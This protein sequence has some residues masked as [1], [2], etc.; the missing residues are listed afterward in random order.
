VVSHEGDGDGAG[1]NQPN[2]GAP[3]PPE[4]DPRGRRRAKRDQA[5]RATTGQA[6]GRVARDQPV[7]S[8]S[9]L[10]A[11]HDVKRGVGIGVR[12]VTA[13]LAVAIVVV[14]GWAWL[15]YHDFKSKI[16]RVNAIGGSGKP[17]TDLDGKDQ[18][19]LVVGN[20][21]R[22]TA[23]DAELR[24]LGTTRDG[25]SYNTDTM[26]V[27]HLPANGE[28]ATVI[29]FPRDSYVAIPGHGTAKLNSAYVDGMV[30]HN[31]NK[32]YG[33]RLLVQT[34]QNLTGL[35][36]DHFVQVDLLGFYRISNAIGG[37]QVNL[38]QAQH[39]ANSGIDL[40]KGVSTVK[41]TQALAFVR[42]RYGLP[43]GDLDR[44][45][46]QQY[47]LSAAFR[48][49]SSA[50]VLLNVFKLQKLLKAVSSSLQMDNSLDPLKLAEQFQALT[51][52]NLIFKTIPT[53]GTQDTDAGNVVVVE[54][55]EVKQ[56]VTQVV[57]SSA[58]SGFGSAKTVSPGSF[59]LDV[60]NGSTADGAASRNADALRQL[61]FRLGVVDTA[62]GRSATTVI[63][64]PDGMQAQAKTL[65][66]HIPGAQGKQTDS[67][68]RVTLLLGTDGL[69]VSAANSTHSFVQRA[70]TTPTPTSSNGMTAADT[71]A[72]IN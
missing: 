17:T 54:P 21:D 40:P 67:V 24:Q 4:L 26:M 47:F 20:D 62:K 11:R 10:T 33:A 48:K 43:N 58:N 14:S 30:D 65:A 25:G 71:G 23:T 64:Y 52:G 8:S 39:E 59:T 69:Q 38:C 55:A 7:G 68:K 18:N 66:A 5:G 60:L 72:C 2:P 1:R 57:G 44:I 50:G 63:E 35:T 22:D 13:V 51:A 12:T 32:A 3:L 28:K 16:P 53:H 46:R 61:G 41:G 27:M 70:V 42:Q 34:I 31:G 56:F 45:K 6:S 9:P 49:V 36:I 37:V 15:T 19:L 29:S